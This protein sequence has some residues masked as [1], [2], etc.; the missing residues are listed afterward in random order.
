MT[1]ILT[2]ATPIGVVMV[3]DSAIT[4][5][6]ANGKIDH[7]DEVGWTKIFRIP[8][9]RGGLSYWGHIGAIRPRFDEW[10]KYLIRKHENVRE[11]KA[12][13]NVVADEMNAALNNHPLQNPA[14]V[15]VAGF[16]A[17]SQGGFTPAIFHIHNGNGHFQGNLATGEW[18]WKRTEP[19]KIFTVHQDF[20][21]P[22]QT[23]WMVRNGEFFLFAQLWEELENAF[24]RINMLE[25]IRIPA[26]NTL[27]AYKGKMHTMVKMVVDLYRI[28]NLHR[29]VGG[30]VVSLGI[31]ENQFIE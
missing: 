10:V 12:F 13:A 4:Y 30:R 31:A 28:S 16:M 24:L 14:G 17:N 6:D 29:S 7:V 26:K 15:H 27:G 5:F 3:A 25:G 11:L 21:R 9:A 22:G 8:M 1:L 23:R 20:P 2:C 19:P 18:G